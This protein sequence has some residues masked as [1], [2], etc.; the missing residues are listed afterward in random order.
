MRLLLER[1]A[2][3]TAKI[4][5]GQA[6]KASCRTGLL[7]PRSSIGSASRGGWRRRAARCRIQQAEDSCQ[8]SWDRDLLTAAQRACTT[9]SGLVTW[10]TTAKEQQ[11][12]N[13]SAC[14][15]KPWPVVPRMKMQPTC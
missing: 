11:G 4:G 2:S 6:S 15:L 8:A 5:N 1:S 9:D 3:G 13:P 12:E 10:T 7:M 14:Y